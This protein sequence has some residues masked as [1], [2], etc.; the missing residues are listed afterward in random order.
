MDTFLHP[1]RFLDLRIERFG[2]SSVLFLWV[3]MNCIGKI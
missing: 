1:I 3:N 2:G